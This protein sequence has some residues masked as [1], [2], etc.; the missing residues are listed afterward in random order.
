MEPDFQRGGPGELEVTIY[1]ENGKGTGSSDDG[2]FP[3]TRLRSTKAMI[4][5]YFSVFFSEFYFS[6]EKMTIQKF[7]FYNYN[8]I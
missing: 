1:S 5:F 2:G 6:I 4:F 7:F 3:E 8:I